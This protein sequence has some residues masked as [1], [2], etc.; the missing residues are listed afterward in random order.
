LDGCHH[1]GADPIVTL[2]LRTVITQIHLLIL[3]QVQAL[4]SRDLPLLV[5]A[6]V[7]LPELAFLPVLVL[8]LVQVQVQVLKEQL[9]KWID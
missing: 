2:T 3:V 7:L 6:P 8:V 9:E 5:Q 4:E 1:Q